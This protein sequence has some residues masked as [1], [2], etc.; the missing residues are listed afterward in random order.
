VSTLEKV[1]LIANCIGVLI[2]AIS[3]GCILFFGGRWV[4][5]TERAAAAVKVVADRLE[6]IPSIQ[7][8]ITFL[9]EE[10]KTV[11]KATGNTPTQS[12]LTKAKT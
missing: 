8:A 4:G 3:V 11:R 10:M 5:R 6:A 7:Q 1:A 9:Q 2:N 12:T